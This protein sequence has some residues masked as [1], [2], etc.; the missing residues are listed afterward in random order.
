MLRS[1]LPRISAAAKP[2]V[3]VDD[4]QRATGFGRPSG[5][6]EPSQTA[7]SRGAGGRR[8]LVDFAA[9]EAGAKLKKKGRGVQDVY[10]SYMKEKFDILKKENPDAPITEIATLAATAYNEEPAADQI[11][12]DIQKKK[13]GAKKKKEDA[14][15]QK[16]GSKRAKKKESKCGADESV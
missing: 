8:I 11:R 3:S 6:P 5:K 12:R 13:D 16:E 14:K 4:Q 10:V 9:V 15:Q 2:P 1:K 7:A